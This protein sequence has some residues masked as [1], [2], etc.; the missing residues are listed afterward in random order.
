[1]EL[2]K[3]TQM[4]I[5]W[6]ESS[7]QLHLCNQSISY[8]LCV[9]P[10]GELGQLYFGKRV[11][12]KEEFTDLTYFGFKSHVAV[13]PGDENFSMELNR[14]EYP[15]FGNTDLGT[16]AYQVIY[17]NGSS[18][19]SFKYAS[20]EIFSGKKGL[21]G[22][23]A[24]YADE[25]E[26][27]TVEITMMNTSANAEM[28]LSYTIFA[29]HAVIVRSTKFR[30]LSDATVK[31]D[32]ALSICMDLPDQDYEWMQFS[33]AWS[34]ERIPVTKK[35][36]RGITSVESRRGVSSANQNPFVILKR[37]NT[38]ENVGEALGFSLLYSGNFIA[39][40]DADT[41]G[42]LRFLMGIHPDGFCWLLKPGEEFHTPEAVMA[43]SG[44]GLNRLSQTFH[45][46]YRNNLI[47]G[48][49][50]NRPK[51]ILLNNWEATF[52]NFTEESIL[53]IAAKAKEAGA[54]LFVLDDGWFGK[55]DDDTSGLGDWYENHKLPGGIRGLAKKVNDL[56]LKF[57]FWIEPEMV[58]PD[59][60]LYRAHPDWAFAVP[61][62]APSLS[63]HQLVLDYSRPEVVD[64]VYDMLFKVLDGANVDYIKWD[65]N[66]SIT[67]CF[68]NTA[69]ADEQGMVYH[70]YVLGV[71]SLYERLIT[72]FPNILFESC[73]S[74]GARFDAGL[75]YYAPQAWC[76]D[77]TD[78]LD[79]IG[80]QMGTSYG[81][82]ISSIGSHVSA[83]PNQQTGRS[84]SIDFRA[85]V[86]Y[87]GTFGYELDLN[88]ISE[89]EFAMVQRQVE[90]MKKNREVI[91]LGDFYRIKPPYGSDVSA[92]MVVSENQ[93]RALLGY[94]VIRARV[95][96]VPQ[97]IKLQGLDPDVRYR[98]GDKVYFGDELMNIGIIPKDNIVPGFT[99]CQDYKSFVLEI[100]SV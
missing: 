88:H 62:K 92:W 24:T 35:I 73:A 28:V 1:M 65:M 39:S 30:N 16:P 61:G 23:P 84:T 27:M 49:Y 19:S 5:I 91:Q 46:L 54:E 82:P 3:D 2:R 58:N 74:G 95:N 44:E 87:F 59:S 26:A 85:D 98:I 86:A 6:H 97:P 50:K 33:G 67:E 41:Y 63:R 43:Y 47:R 37:E 93:K 57:G 89:E 15:S 36:D 13:D 10:N 11:H 70:K 69:A 81:Y 45:K 7:R 100:E 29:D 12:D 17:P 31:L 52:M 79:R 9:Q 18:V 78:A 76:S 21:P 96:S 90:F 51:P 56:G 8:I 94:Y 71:Y 55:R 75:L 72:A 22:M 83:V 77:N 99:E 68:S 20:H 80:I 14:Q 4:N 64:A 53:E 40:A 32:R 60:D 66:R 38:D 25:K 42:R 34:R 48:K